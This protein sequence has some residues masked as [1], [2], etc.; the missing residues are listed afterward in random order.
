MGESLEELLFLVWMPEGILYILY[1]LI[2]FSFFVAIILDMFQ[3]IFVHTGNKGRKLAI[4]TLKYKEN[5]KAFA[6][7]LVFFPHTS[8]RK[9]S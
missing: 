4:L 9:Q 2:F 5:L 6:R 3:S 1:L 7:F 8:Y